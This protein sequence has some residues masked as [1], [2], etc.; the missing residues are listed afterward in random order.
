M[1]AAGDNGTGIPLW[2]AIA[3]PFVAAG[4]V[5]LFG[6]LAAKIA[7]SAAENA[8]TIA[9]ESAAKDA[10]ERSLER[11][12]EQQCWAAR[13]DAYST[14]LKHIFEFKTTCDEARRAIETHGLS[15]LWRDSTWAARLR[16]SQTNCQLVIATKIFFFT[17][18]VAR[19]TAGFGAAIDEQ[20]EAAR[21][22]PLQ[23]ATEQLPMRLKTL[24]DAAV[25]TM[26]DFRGAV[27]AELGI[28]EPDHSSDSLHRRDDGR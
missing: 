7:A 5:G 27:M 10:V 26:T 2:I 18:R 19:V 17:E 21:D 3:S 20:I 22:L 24:S 4:L 14:I 8:A 13:S 11:F 12:R 6:I 16:E 9:A 1:L 28:E 25:T 15:G 23:V